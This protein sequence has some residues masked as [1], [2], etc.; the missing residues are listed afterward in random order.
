MSRAV[1]SSIRLDEAAGVAFVWCRENFEAIIDIEDLPLVEGKAW[2]LLT[3]RDGHA[4]AYTRSRD[5]PVLLMHRMLM[6]SLP[7]E[8][9]DHKDGDGLNNRRANMRHGSHSQNQANKAADRRSK[10]GLKGVTQKRNRFKA[11]ITTKGRKIYIG[12]FAT[13]EE[14]AAAYQGAAKILWGDFAFDGEQT[15]ISPTPP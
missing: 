4:Y 8:I 6:Q 10:I 7:G 12:S 11:C 2:R 14:A 15:K 1:P 13:A 9:V 3:T 5:N